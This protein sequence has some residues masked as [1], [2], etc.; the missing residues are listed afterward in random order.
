MKMSDREFLEWIRDRI[1]HVYGESPNV[2]FV[3]KLGKIAAQ[4]QPIAYV[5][6]WYNGRCVIEPLDRAMAIPPKMA[7]YSQP[8]AQ[9]GDGEAVIAL[10]AAQMVVDAWNGR[11]TIELR[12]ALD[13]LAGS[14]NADG[15]TRPQ[16]QV[17]QQLPFVWMRSEDAD[18][19]MIASEGERAEVAPDKEDGFDIPLY[20]RPQPAVDRQDLIDL[21]IATRTQ[22]EGVT[23]DLIIE[24]LG[25]KPQANQQ[26]PKPMKIY[27][28]QPIDTGSKNYKAGWNACLAAIAAAQ[29][30]L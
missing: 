20:T 4:A 29:E 25:A 26:L 13:Y 11:M 18:R 2:D 15:Y 10:A 19:S 6:G 12:A 5:T 30:Q 7:L 14:V 16:P 24:M 23:A 8:Q 3:Q 9:A 27:T 1:V 22:S 17:N 28:F 21:L